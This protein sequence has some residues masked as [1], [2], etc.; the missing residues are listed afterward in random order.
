MAWS[1]AK[2]KINKGQRAKQAPDGTLVFTKD[3]VTHFTQG[4]VSSHD[5]DISDEDRAW[6]P[7]NPLDYGDR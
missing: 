3:Q 1:N 5:N 7:G 4:F 6:M 2:Y